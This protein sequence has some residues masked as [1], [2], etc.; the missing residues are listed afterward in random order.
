MSTSSVNG[1]TALFNMMEVLASSSN[2]GAKD[3]VMLSKIYAMAEFSSQIASLLEKMG[4]AVKVEN[5]LKTY[6]AENS[7][8]KGPLNPQLLA[9]LN[10]TLATASKDNSVVDALNAD[11]A[12]CAAN[13]DA[14]K[15]S[16][17]TSYADCVAIVAMNVPWYVEL[18]GDTAVNAYIA[19]YALDMSLENAKAVAN[20]AAAQGNQIAEDN[21]KLIPAMKAATLD[22][23][24]ASSEMSIQ[25]QKDSTLSEAQIK[26][27][28]HEVDASMAIFSA[29]SNICGSN[30]PNAPIT[31][32]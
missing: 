27:D 24:R 5:F 9:L 21:Q 17:P 29:Y 7:N 15:A 6:L 12:Q 32:N 28:A 25:G 30:N 11:I 14:F 26:Q 10:N 13:I 19:A 22:M 3:Q 2:T 1:D 23:N 8:G 20:Y 18:G 31:G 16:H 4:D